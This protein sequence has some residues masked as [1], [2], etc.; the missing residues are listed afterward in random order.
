MKGNPRHMPRAPHR[1]EVLPGLRAIQ[2][3]RAA[4]AGMVQAAAAAPEGRG[5]LLLVDPGI[6]DGRLHEE[7]LSAERIY[8]PELLARLSLV[9]ARKGALRG[10][11]QEPDAALRALLAPHLPQASKPADA[12]LPR[13]DFGALVLQL[14]IHQWLNDLGP[15]TTDWLQ[16]QAGCSYPTVAAALKQLGPA[17]QRHHDRRVE[18]R[19][20]PREEWAAL[21]ASAERV[22]GTARFADR[23]GQPRSAES[24]LKRLKK[25]GRTDLAVGGVIGARRHHPGL[26]LAGTP[27]LDLTLHC[28]RRSADLSFVEQLDPALQRTED[29]D[30][31]ASLVVHLLRRR[32]P[33]FIPYANGV[34]WA[35]AVECLLDLHEA[36][37]E[38]QAEAFV[39]H[40]S[41]RRRAPA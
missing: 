13:A 30:A 12:L 2:G 22:R 14:L 17:L 5:V 1:V 20:F 18:L 19:R 16:K 33:L 39:E 23:S 32:A 4:L 6:T 34:P 7:W 35:D 28:P 37:L 31:P 24:L 27:R 26:D 40:F 9:A 38:P 25:L 21:L 29:R 3:F 11:P 15:V 8:R 10:W 41:A 36:R